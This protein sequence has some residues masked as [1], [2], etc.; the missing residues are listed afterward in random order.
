MYTILY[1]ETDKQYLIHRLWIWESI[2]YP[3]DRFLLLAML[4]L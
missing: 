1:L 2:D 3:M 4:L